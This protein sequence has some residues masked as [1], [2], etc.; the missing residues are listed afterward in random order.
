MNIK[1]PE[2]D[3]VV[4]EIASVDS[5]YNFMHAIADARIALHRAAS[6]LSTS[7]PIS[8]RLEDA[9][10]KINFTFED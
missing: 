5:Y 3:Y 2:Q 8:H 4:P 7:G 9:L 1:K 6:C 10:E